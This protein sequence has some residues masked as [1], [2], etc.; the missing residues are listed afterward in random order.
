MEGHQPVVV[1]DCEGSLAASVGS[2]AASVGKA[3]S[4]LIY[5]V[6]KIQRGRA[7]QQKNKSKKVKTD[8]SLFFGYF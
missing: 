6:E 1:R 4:P 7:A 2:L 3:K 5:E 8:V